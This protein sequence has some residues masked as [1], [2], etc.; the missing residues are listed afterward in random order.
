MQIV[1]APTQQQSTSRSLPPQLRFDNV[2]SSRTSRIC[3][4][5]TCIIIHIKMHTLL[6][7]GMVASKLRLLQH[8][9]LQLS[10][11]RFRTL[12]RFRAHS[13]S[14]I[15]TCSWSLCLSLAGVW[16]VLQVFCILQLNWI[17]FIFYDIFCLFSL[18]S[19]N[20]LATLSFSLSFFPAVLFSYSFTTP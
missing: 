16:T 10:L 1:N 4:I 9:S 12:T 3:Y 11:V 14:F 19:H 13:C 18:F 17:N 7:G 6:I 5:H 20:L 8:S 2:N 15:C